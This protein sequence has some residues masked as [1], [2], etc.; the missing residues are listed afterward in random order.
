MPKS[1][2]PAKQLQRFMFDDQ[3]I[4]EV[5]IDEAGRGPMF[6][7][8]YAA[9]VILPKDETAFP[10][11]LMKDSKKFTNFKKLTEAAH[12]IME[13]SIAYS[14]KYAENTEIDALNPLKST[15]K[16][17]NDCVSDILEQMSNKTQNQDQTFHLLVDGSYFRPRTR[18]SKN[19]KTMSN[20]P[21]TCVTSGDD[22]Y[23]SIAAAS[24]LAKYHRD[25][26]I[27]KLC[28]ENQGLDD[29]YDLRKNKG[30]GTKK[31]LDAI[32]KIGITKW[33]RRTFGICKTATLIEIEYQDEDQLLIHYLE[34]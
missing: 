1:K 26:Y 11:E 32:R 4:L 27:D 33:H 30:Y 34:E 19:G 24:I 22:T 12:I 15:M 13:K 23:T 14:V 16:I 29:V 31:H 17:M 10:H 5:G 25:T 28:D 9:A 6:G 18:I 3:D 20:I 8:V 2:A 7:R 21:Y